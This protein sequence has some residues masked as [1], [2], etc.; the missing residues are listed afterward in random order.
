MKVAGQYVCR[1]CKQGVLGILVENEAKEASDGM[2][3]LPDLAAHTIWHTCYAAT[4]PHATMGVCD[5]VGLNIFTEQ[6]PQ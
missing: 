5:F 6:E 2:I 1:R 4:I 3:V